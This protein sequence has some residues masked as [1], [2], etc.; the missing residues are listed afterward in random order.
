MERR[1]DGAEAA[2]DH[3]EIVVIEPVVRAEQPLQVRPQ[4]GMIDEIAVRL[5]PTQQAPEAA[6]R[7]AGSGI[8][9]GARVVQAV[10]RLQFVIGEDPLDDEEALE[11][12]EIPF[13]FV[14]EDRS[15]RE[16]N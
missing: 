12:E 10:Q 3:V 14:H 1:A 11:I 7:V 6:R 13:D 16:R 15:S 5:A 9:R 4:P 2:R 8:R